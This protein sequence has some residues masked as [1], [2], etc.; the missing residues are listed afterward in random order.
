MNLSAWDTQWQCD[1]F[2][3]RDKIAEMRV[4]TRTEKTEL[5]TSVGDR[6]EKQSPLREN[7]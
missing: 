5:W 7:F 6:D 4:P 3:P 2:K 1:E